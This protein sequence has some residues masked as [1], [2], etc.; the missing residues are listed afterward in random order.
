MSEEKLEAIKKISQCY[1]Q[2]SDENKRYLVGYAVGYAAGREDK[3]AE[4]GQDSP[5]TDTEIQV[6]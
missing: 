2:M 6:E 3:S 1:D 4:P 5:Q